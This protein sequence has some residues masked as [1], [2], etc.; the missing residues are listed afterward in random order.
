MNA[1]S[2][3]WLSNCTSDL[4]PS[5]IRLAGAAPRTTVAVCITGL[6]RSLLSKPVTSSFEGMVRAPIVASGHSVYPFIVLSE[7]RS[8]NET[9]RLRDRIT[10]AYRPVSLRLQMITE[11]PTKPK[12]RLASFIGHDGAGS[13]AGIL[14]HFTVSACFDDVAAEEH[15]RGSAYGWVLR[16]RTDVVL[17]VSFRI[18]LR[19]DHVYVPG[20]GM[21]YRSWLRCS[22]DH[23]FLCPRELCAPYATLIHNFNNASCVPLPGYAAGGDGVLADGT[24][25]PQP[26]KMSFSWHIPR[27]YNASDN[28]TLFPSGNN[29]GKVV[30]MIMLYAIAR[31]SDGEMGAISCENNLKFMWANH[32]RPTRQSKSRQCAMSE[33][34]RISTLYHGGSPLESAEVHSLEKRL[35]QKEAQQG[36]HLTLEDLANEPTIRSRSHH[37]TPPVQ[38]A[39]GSHR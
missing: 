32:H 3:S 35:Y 28:R 5:P 22:N 31:G 24:L 4:P 26:A 36:L 6:L 29:C 18:P 2:Q 23:M 16:L 7:Q 14:Q 27:A 8:S 33:C 37:Q 17:F 12:C 15:R 11:R 38:S 19:A 21:S 1:D 13:S 30:E 9:S 25:R 20:G 34:Q 39:I 10:S